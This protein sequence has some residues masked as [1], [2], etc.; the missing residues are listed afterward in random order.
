MRYGRVES[1]QYALCTYVKSS[2]NI[3]LYFYNIFFIM[4]LV[5]VAIAVMEHHTQ[6]QLGEKKEF[7]LFSYV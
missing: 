5:R 7:I 3:A 1:G 4:C 6:K 2:K